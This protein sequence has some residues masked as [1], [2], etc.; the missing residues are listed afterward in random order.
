[1]Q[2]SNKFL[3]GMAVALTLTLAACAP[4]PNTPALQNMATAKKLKVVA[5]FSILG[6]FVHN[7]AGDQINLTT[8]VGPNS[9]THDFEPNPSD[10]ILLAQADVI[11]ENGLGLETWLDNLY[12]SS[13]STALR[14]VASTGVNIHHSPAGAD[15]HIWQDPQRAIQMVKTIATGL[16][17]ADPSHADTYKTNADAFIRKLAVL[18]RDINT[19]IQAIPPSDR[20]MITSHDA[21]GYF[22]EHYHIELIGS[23]IASLSTE[24]GEPSAQDIAKL[25]DAIKTTNAKAIFLETITNPAVVE[26]VAK[27]AGVKVAPALYTDALGA[28]A[29]PGATY[30]EAMRHNARVITEALR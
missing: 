17:A 20:K 8:L 30:L 28:P 25:V 22:A 16:S 18:D 29:S 14:V 3:A 21:L 1:M 10:N 11:V 2:Q 23:V 24:T 7:I 13:R 5:T 12:T 26:R 19:A 4:A 15:P 6:D 9:D 27:E